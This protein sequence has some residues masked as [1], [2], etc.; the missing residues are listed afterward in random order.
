MGVSLLRS[1]FGDF[2]SLAFCASLPQAIF[3]ERIS[4]FFHPVLGLQACLL[5]EREYPLLRVD[6]V[7]VSSNWHGMYCLLWCQSIFQPGAPAR[8]PCYQLRGPPRD[9]YIHPNE[10]SKDFVYCTFLKYSI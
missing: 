9:P 7:Y 2:H 8:R 10:A 6:D 1:P 5:S 4:G 3:N